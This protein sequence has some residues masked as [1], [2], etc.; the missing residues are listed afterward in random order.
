MYLISSFH[1]QSGQTKRFRREEQTVFFCGGSSWFTWLWSHDGWYGCWTLCGG[2]SSWRRWHGAFAFAPLCVL[3]CGHR[4]LWQWLAFYLNCYHIEGM[5]DNPLQAFL[6]SINSNLALCCTHQHRFKAVAR[7]FLFDKSVRL[8]ISFLCRRFVS[9]LVEIFPV[10][11]LFAFDPR[12]F[13][14]FLLFSQSKTKD[15]KIT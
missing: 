11:F 3:G 10:F 9:Y 14:V 12:V 8:F 13:T 7:F 6:T 15:R 5:A 2:T 4:R 1:R